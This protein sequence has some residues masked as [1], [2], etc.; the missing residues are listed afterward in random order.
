MDLRPIEPKKSSFTPCLSDELSAIAWNPL[1]SP[2]GAA[3]SKFYLKKNIW[4]FSARTS[5]DW[6]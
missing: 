5:A 1:P 4:F 6:S 3:E 2:P